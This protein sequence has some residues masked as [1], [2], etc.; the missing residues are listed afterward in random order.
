MQ[1]NRLE[2]F[3]DG[4]LAIIITIMVLEIKVPHGNEWNDL[5]ALLPK[6][7]S[8]VLSFLY[9]GIYWG[10]HHNLLHTAPSVNSRVMLANLHLLFW[11]SLI[12]FTTGWMGENHMASR[13]VALYSLNLLIAGIAYSILQSTIQSVGGLHET[14]SAALKKHRYKGI[15]SMISYFTAIA[16]AFIEPLVSVIIAFGAAVMWLIPDKDIEIA[17]TETEQAE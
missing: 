17:V 6:F 7:I 8:Y 1:R 16:F 9:I 11:L 12:P 5:S 10:N 15:I 13:P 3:S 14:I 2:A 4:V